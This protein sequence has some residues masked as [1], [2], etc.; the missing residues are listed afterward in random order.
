MR[1]S[2]W[3]L[4]GAKAAPDDDRLSRCRRFFAPRRSG[5]EG[6]LRRLRTIWR[7]VTDPSIERHGGRI[8]KTTGDGLLLEFASAVEAARCALEVQRTM[9]ARNASL[10][11]ADRMA[12]R[13][14]INVGDVV[15]DD[16]DLLGEAVNIA[17]RLEKLA[18]PGGVCLSQAARDHIGDRV[19]IA[20]E[21]LGE[22]SLHNIARTVRCYRIAPDG[23]KASSPVS[24]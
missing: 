22:Q 4:G 18:E 16:E 2:G 19:S 8:V 6:T 24:R 10:A 20:L 1:A 9:V 7:D 14:G 21:D 23:D 12:L 5:R 11:E 17:A 3:N 13:I 15:A